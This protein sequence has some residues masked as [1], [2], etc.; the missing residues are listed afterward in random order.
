MSEVI[1]NIFSDPEG[2]THKLDLPLSIIP[3]LSPS[4]NIQYQA[5]IIFLGWELKSMEF[6]HLVSLKDLLKVTR[7]LHNQKNQLDKVRTY[8]FKPIRD[9]A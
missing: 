4:H 3:T 2:R 8:L 5:E 7:K 6:N 1:F 9:D